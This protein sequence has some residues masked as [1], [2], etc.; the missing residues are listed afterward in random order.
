M[1]NGDKATATLIKIYKNTLHGSNVKH[2]NNNTKQID[3]QLLFVGKNIQYN[4]S[5]QVVK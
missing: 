3:N 2:L 4:W 5:F 1:N